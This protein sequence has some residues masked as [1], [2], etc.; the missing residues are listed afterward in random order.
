MGRLDRYIEKRDFSRTPEPSDGGTGCGLALRYSIQ[1]HHARRTHFDLRLEWDGALLSWAV[2]RG[3]SFHPSDKRLA[4]RTEDHPLSYLDF[5]GDIPDGNYGAGQVMLFDI[6]HWQPTEPV[7]KGLKK[8]H[9]RF[10][11]HGRR[12]TGGWHLV[13]MKGHRSGDGHRENWL[14]MKG[15]DEAAGRRDPVARY[16]RSVR[17][18]RTLRE[19]AAEKPDRVPERTGRQPKF[20]PVQLATLSDEVQPTDK[21]WHELKFDGYRALISLGRSGTRIF[22]R[23]GHDWSDRFASLLP[24]FDD[25]KCGSA[26]IDGEIIAGAGLQGFSALQSAIK[27]GGPYQFFAFDLLEL[28]GQ[29]ATAKPL[30]ERRALLEP[31]LG[32]VPPLGQIQLSPVISSDPQD[33]FANIC[34]AGGEGLIAKR[35]DAPYRGGRSR[36][37]LKIKCE[38]RDEFVILG[39]QKSDKAGRPFASLALGTLGA[40]DFDY[41]GKVGTGFDDDTMDAIRTALGKLKEHAP[42]ANVSKDEAH[43]VTWVEPRL[44]AEVKYSEL[45][46]DKRLR[47]AVFLGLREDKRAR[48]VKLEADAMPDDA[49]EIADVRITHPDRT[50]YPEA[51]ITKREVADYYAAV[52]DRMVPKLDDRP[53]SLVRLP[54]GLS[55]DRFF[56]KHLGKGFPSAILATEIKESDGSPATY[57]RVKDAS[58]LVG[59]VQMG[60]LEFHIWGARRDNL[61]RPDRLVFDLDPDEGLGF[62]EVKSAAFDIRDILSDLGLDCWPMVTG[63][64]GVHVVAPLRRVAEWDTVKLFSQVLATHLAQSEPERFTASMS[65]SKR[66]GRIF[67][68]WLR[69]ER[70]ATAIAPFSLRARE[71][72]PV[73]VAVSWDELGGLRS[74][75]AFGMEA[76]LEREAPFSETPTAGLSQNKIDALEK[77]ISG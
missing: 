66:S 50:V 28:D 17:S 65:K 25:L 45:T 9:L 21:W 2:T 22:T 41:L 5:E 69:N 43:S 74:A 68:D 72:A 71:G 31:L 70:G 7:E 36:N 62:G 8:G 6:G 23:N 67:I 20:K 51:G 59:A 77:M 35:I 24:A 15:E 46:G 38:K 75:Q 37:W 58:G 52:A 29:S 19:I 63:G 30:D 73:A 11:L 55:G 47:H 4:V 53:L 13:R 10:V 64:K 60:T 16:R 14:L 49:V 18:G 1:E 76:A 3:P 12:L 44:V 27:S 33:A 54:E 48:T 39:W 32:D 57:M 42:P 40:A 56:Q 61:E 34:R 26:L